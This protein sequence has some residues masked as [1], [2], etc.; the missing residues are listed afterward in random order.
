MGNKKLLCSLPL[1]LFLSV[2][3][4][5]QRP[6]PSPPTTVVIAVYS[7]GAEPRCGRGMVVAD[8]MGVA[9]GWC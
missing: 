6:A 8:G 5:T 3:W 1:P 9:R 2:D 7:E 4:V